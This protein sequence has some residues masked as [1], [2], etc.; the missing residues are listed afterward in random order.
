MRKTGGILL[1]ALFAVAVATGACG[2][3]DDEDET[4]VTTATTISPGATVSPP[5]GVTT[6]SIAATITTVQ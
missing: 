1:T 4:S 6:T 3:D 2:D 5:I